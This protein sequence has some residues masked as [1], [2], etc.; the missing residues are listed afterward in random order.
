MFKYIIFT[1]I[2]ALALS[3][4]LTFN[5][6]IACSLESIANIPATQIPNIPAGTTSGWS[7]N[8]TTS[9]CTQMSIPMKG[10][11]SATSN[12]FASQQDCMKNC[13]CIKQLYFI[14]H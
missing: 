12:F 10:K 11:F 6:A 1:V 14:I 8:C 2:F 7:F 5:P 3:Q 13:P 9:T 4:P